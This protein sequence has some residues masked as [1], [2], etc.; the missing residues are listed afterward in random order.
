MVESLLE[1][2]GLFCN[3]IAI[4]VRIHALIGV[5]SHSHDTSLHFQ[6]GIQALMM[7]VIKVPHPFTCHILEHI[8]AFGTIALAC[9][10][11]TS[12]ELSFDVSSSDPRRYRHRRRHG[13]CQSLIVAGRAQCPHQ[14]AN[15]HCKSRQ[16]VTCP[17]F[18]TFQLKE[19]NGGDRKRREKMLELECRK[20]T[21]G[22]IF[23]YINKRRIVD[24][25]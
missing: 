9:T 11:N 22:A 17:P 7:G 14:E 5:Y 18:P 12:S 3:N 21:L 2:T 6:P 15:Q 23:V 10:V 24:S 13:I 4:T 25:T 20:G 16:V 1:G 8:F 19:K